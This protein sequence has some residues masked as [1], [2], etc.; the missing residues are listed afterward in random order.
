MSVVFIFN[1]PPNSGKDFAC[2]KMLEHFKNS[3]H[4]MFKEQLYEKAAA[5][6]GLDL[7]LFKP[8]ATDR[9]TK[10]VPTK[11]LSGYSPRQWMIHVSEDLVKP[12]F[13][14]S[15]FGKQVAAK[16]TAD[17][18]FISDGGFYDEILPLTEK[19]S[20]FLVQ[21]SR[22]GCSFEG[23]SRRYITEEEAN[24]LGCK[25]VK[26]HNNGTPAFVKELIR[27][28]YQKYYELFEQEGE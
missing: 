14:S 1:S 27:V 2:G 24:Q 10:E 23:D 15:F 9:D 5:L 18:V 12:K 8:L 3:Q 11:L 4:L 13:G 6:A 26:I 21:I 7:Q 20:V 16:I 19:H 17:V 28:V 25:I 22:E